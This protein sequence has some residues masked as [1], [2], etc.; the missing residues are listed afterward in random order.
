MVDY[1]IRL[2]N[3]NDY[4][5]YY[6]LINNFQETSFSKEDFCI[7]LDR[8]EKNIEIWVIEYNNELVATGTILYE[9]KFIHNISLYAH[10]EDICVSSSFRGGGYG[11]ILMDYL[12]KRS[13]EQECYKIILDCKENLEYFYNK[14]GFK[15]NG[16]QMVIYL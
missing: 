9:Y 7:M 5:K 11:L 16:L 13:R 3:K 6:I 12:V 15:K 14:S 10:I 8:I 1:I 4:D 2:L